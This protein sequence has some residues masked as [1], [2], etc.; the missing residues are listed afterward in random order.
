[1]PELGRY[2]G[3]GDGN[4][5]QYSCLENAID[6]AAWWALA[7]GVTKSH[8]RLSDCHS[9]KKISMSTNKKGKQKILQNNNKEKA[10]YEIYESESE[11]SQLCPTLQ[12]PMDCSP[13]GSSVRGIFQA[14][15]LEWVAISFSGG[16][17]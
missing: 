6:R 3:E 17:S 7:H 12:D 13:P 1:M 8:T 2:P 5:L 14:R 16:S 11:V 10:T 4:P 15:V 9:L